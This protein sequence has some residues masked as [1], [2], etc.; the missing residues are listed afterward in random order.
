[1]SS[2]RGSAANAAAKVVLPTPPLPIN[3]SSP[4]PGRSISSTSAPSGGRPPGRRFAFGDPSLIRSGAP[5]QTYGAHRCRPDSPSKRESCARKA[6]ELRVHCRQRGRS[7]LPKA[8]AS[9]SSS[10]SFGISPL[11]ASA[12]SGFR[13]RANSRDVRAASPSAES[14]GVATRTSHV[15]ATLESCSTAA[16]IAVACF[17]RPASGPRQDASPAPSSRKPDHAPG[18]LRSRMVWP[19]RRRIEYDMVISP[20]QVIVGQER[21]EFIESGDLSRTCARELLLDALEGL[22]WQNPAHGTDE[23]SRY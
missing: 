5:G 9:G 10:T 18:N 12:G 20:H 7:R 6:R 13:S 23:R 4:L 22:L 21:C 8:A 3:M 14:R 11:M 17:S 19:G 2:G 1:M 16:D 15:V